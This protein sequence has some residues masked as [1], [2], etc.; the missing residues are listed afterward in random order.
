ME[1]IKFTLDDVQEG[2]GI[3]V[4]GTDFIGSV[5][6]FFTGQGSHI[7]GVARKDGK[8]VLVE[9]L[10][11]GCVISPLDKYYGKYKI[12]I[13]RKRGEL[14]QGQKTILSEFWLSGVGH[15]PYSNQEDIGL[16]IGSILS[17]LN[18]FGWQPFKNIHAWKN[19]FDNG[20]GKFC[21]QF[22]QDG[23]FKIGIDLAPQDTSDNTSPHDCWTSP[24]MVQKAVIDINKQA[25]A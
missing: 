9:M 22:Y 1:K 5:V 21:S 13:L 2:D 10:Q 15:T 11:E 23:Y 19:P 17:E 14:N 20:H 18:L 6:Q 4:F 8:L 12:G 24:L 3:V 25:Y 7:A 16:G